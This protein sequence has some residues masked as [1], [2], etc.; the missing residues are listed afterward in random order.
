MASAT[1]ATVEGGAV[2]QQAVADLAAHS[3]VAAHIDRLAQAGGTAS[4]IYGWLLP[5]VARVHSDEDV[6]RLFTAPQTTA[7]FQASDAIGPTSKSS[8][9]STSASAAQALG[10]GAP[11]AA[12]IRKSALRGLSVLE[13]GLLVAAAHVEQV[14]S[15]LPYFVSIC[16]LYVHSSCVCFAQR[17]A[18]KVNARARKGGAPGVAAV[19]GQGMVAAGDSL[20]PPALNFGLIYAEYCAFAG[21]PAT[22]SASIGK[23]ANAASAGTGAGASASGDVLTPAAR[24]AHNAASGTSSRTMPALA[25][26]KKKTSAATTESAALQGAS[27]DSATAALSQAATKAAAA[28]FAA[29]AEAAARASSTSGSAAA[30]SLSLELCDNDGHPQFAGAGSGAFDVRLRMDAATAL[31]AF[32]RLVAADLLRLVPRHATSGGG[33]SSL[34]GSGSVGIAGTGAVGS[35]VGGGGGSAPGGGV[36]H[37]SGKELLAARADIA[38]QVCMRYWL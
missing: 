9:T 31:R 23:Q 2:W 11:S 6:I 1:A 12:A 20:I 22:A 10:V 17:D 3:R 7:L 36:S 8:A 27:L 33:G 24:A 28:S 16:Q 18:G 34:G 29:A 26:H 14:C 5:A 37:W 35:G 21:S 30:L 32:E 38:T 13:A 25:S 19:G 15:L 4:S